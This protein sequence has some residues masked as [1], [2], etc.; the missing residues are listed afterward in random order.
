MFAGKH[1]AAVGR[2]ARRRR[3]RVLGDARGDRAGPGRGRARAAANPSASASSC[4]RRSRASPRSSPAAWSRPSSSTS[5]STTRSRTSCAARAR[6]RR[7]RAYGPCS[8]RSS[9]ASRSDG[10]TSA[11]ASSAARTA[12]KSAAAATS[13]TRSMCAPASTPYPTAASVPAEPLARRTAGDRA[14]EVLAG[15][16]QQQRPPERVQPLELAQRLD[17]LRRRLAEVGTRVEHQLLERHARGR[18]RAR[19]ARA[20]TARRPSTTRPSSVGS[21]S[22]CLGA[23][24][25]CISTRP[26]PVSRAHVGK[27]RVAQPADV[28]DDRRAGGDRRARDGGLVG[29]DRDQRAELARDVLD[30]RHDPLDLLRRVDRRAVGDAG[31]PADVDHVGARVEQLRGELDRARSSVCRSPASENESGV[32]LTIPISHGRPPSAS[33]PRVVRSG[34][35]R[36]AHSRPG[37]LTAIPSA[38]ASSANRSTSTARRARSSQPSSRAERARPRARGASA[39]GPTARG[40]P[41]ARAACGAAA[42]R[43]PSAPARGGPRTA[44]SASR[45]GSPGTIG[46]A[47]S[48]RS[49]ASA[50]TCS[51]AWP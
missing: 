35:G 29:V 5:S 46:W 28:V 24:R 13:W 23:A 33:V 3:A 12:R 38:S 7:P 25:V 51:A 36:R 2:A 48:P 39:S 27:L 40:R 30:Q 8:R 31:L 41:A 26:A 17:R 32:A 20:E 4:S 18:P 47:S 6:P 42:R 16:R 11:P 15:D 10:S 45:S 22:F 44:A 9:S 34:R 14:D 50:S 21:S 43:R 49:A 1:R 19:S 37:E